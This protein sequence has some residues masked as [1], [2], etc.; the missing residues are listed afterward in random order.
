MNLPFPIHAHSSHAPLC[1]AL[2]P[3]LNFIIG[4]PLTL[5]IAPW[6]GLCL[7]FPLPPDICPH[8]PQLSG[9]LLPIL[10]ALIMKSLRIMH[11]CGCPQLYLHAALMPH[12]A[13]LSALSFPLDAG[14]ALHFATAIS[15]SC[16]MVASCSSENPVSSS[17]I[18]T[19]TLF[20]DTKR[21]T[22]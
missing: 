15:I 11:V 14:D 18:V 3:S 9:H 20:L 21:N 10:S 13:M 5:P 4:V 1:T 19:A 7:Q 2:R 16:V 8:M 17:D 12:C 22:E 6:R